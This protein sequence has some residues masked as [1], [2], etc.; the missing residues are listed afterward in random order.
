MLTTLPR[1]IH[2]FKCPLRIQPLTTKIITK[3][4]LIL[5][6]QLTEVKLYPSEKYIISDA[7]I[8][9]YTWQMNLTVKNLNKSDFLPYICSSINALGKSDARIRLQGK[10]KLEKLFIAIKK[11]LLSLVVRKW[12]KTFA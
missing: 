3:N 8:N 6:F 2:G 10:N 12:E 1:K 11:S 7:Q 5:P 9:S 4:P